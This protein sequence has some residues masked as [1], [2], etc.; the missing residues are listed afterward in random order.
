MYLPKRINHHA[1]FL[2]PFWGWLLFFKPF[3][4]SSALFCQS[5]VLRPPMMRRLK[6]K[7]EH[8]SKR[9]KSK[10][11]QPTMSRWSEIVGVKKH[12]KI[13][14]LSMVFFKHSLCWLPSYISNECRHHWLE[15]SCVAKWKQEIIGVYFYKVKSQRCLDFTLRNWF[16]FCR[17]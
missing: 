15:A 7:W 5:N 3:F 4:I 1:T 12:Y 17:I 11:C 6:Q 10:A 9:I 14:W 13:R 8:P 16:Y 2:W